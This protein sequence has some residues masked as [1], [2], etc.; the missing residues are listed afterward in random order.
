LKTGNFSGCFV[1]RHWK[2]WHRHGYDLASPQ[3]LRFWFHQNN[4][5]TINK[6]IF[7]MFLFIIMKLS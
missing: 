6:E 1:S 5:S 7:L 3:I 4:Q 2:A